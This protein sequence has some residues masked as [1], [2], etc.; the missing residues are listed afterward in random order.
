MNEAQDELAVF[1][2]DVRE[3]DPAPSSLHHIADPGVR[4]EIGQMLGGAET[5]LDF[6][7]PGLQLLAIVDEESATAQRRS[8]GAERLLPQ[9][10]FDRKM[11]RNARILPQVPF[12]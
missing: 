4:L 2:D 10:D 5:H 8:V 7:F 1:R 12:S 9:R 11:G 3:L 6:G